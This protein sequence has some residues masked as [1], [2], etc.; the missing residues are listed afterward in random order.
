MKHRPGGAYS[1]ALTKSITNKFDIGYEFEYSCFNGFQDNPQFSAYYF[2]HYIIS[3]MR[4]EPVKYHS[5]VKSNNAEIIYHF[6][7]SE[8]KRTIPFIYLKGGSTRLFSTL[9]YKSSNE[10]IFSKTGWDKNDPYSSSYVDTRNFGF[11]GGD[12][13]VI[14]PKVSLTIQGD[15]N[16]VND[17]NLDGVQNFK[18]PPPEGYKNYVSGAY[19]RL[20]LSLCY[21]FNPD[22]QRIAER[23]YLLIDTFKKKR[24]L[25]LWYKNKM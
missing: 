23:K 17:D 7:S 6:K 3:K 1:I 9:S 12:E 8:E 4:L 22:R 25:Y 16:I 11:G 5:Y 19:I 21:N 20:Q 2:G 24:K 13:I 14:S 10:E 18:E 15:F